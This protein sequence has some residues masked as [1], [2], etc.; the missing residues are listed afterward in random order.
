MASQENNDAHHAGSSLSVTSLNTALPE[1]DNAHDD[2]H[3]TDPTVADSTSPSAPETTGSCPTSPAQLPPDAPPLWSSREGR[4]A[5]YRRMIQNN[6]MPQ[7]NVN[8][9]ALIRYYEDGGKVPEG[10]EEVWAVEGEV[11]FGIRFYAHSDEF[12]EGWFRKLR[13]CDVSCPSISLCPS[14]S[15]QYGLFVLWLQ[16][17]AITEICVA[18]LPL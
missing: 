8:L 10:N 13:Y 9:E 12:P 18:N 15:S 16:G 11:S 4:I 14:H 6:H 3:G 5:G 1:H 17:P 2:H 7:Q